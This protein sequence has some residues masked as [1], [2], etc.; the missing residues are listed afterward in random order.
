MRASD[1]SVACGL[2]KSRFGSAI[3]SSSI[4]SELRD[5]GRP[6]PQ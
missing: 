4:A 5:F 6:Q 2:A 3:E 1:P